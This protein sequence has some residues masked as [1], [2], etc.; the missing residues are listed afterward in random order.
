MIGRKVGFSNSG[1]YYIGTF[2][3]SI[4]LLRALDK[5]SNSISVFLMAKLAFR[6]TFMYGLL[7]FYSFGSLKLMLI[8]PKSIFWGD[9]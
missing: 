9:L 7:G 5:V 4:V 2:F 1:G 8:L 6:S 3:S